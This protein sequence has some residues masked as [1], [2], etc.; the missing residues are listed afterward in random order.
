[1]RNKKMG[2]LAVLVMLV[3]VTLNA[4]GGTYAK[5]ISSYGMTDEARV[6]RWDFTDEKEAT[7]T[8]DLFQQSYTVA[9]NDEGTAVDEHTWVASSD[10]WKV[11]APGT[12]GMYEYSIKGTAET[13]FK[14][15]KVLSIT[16][17][18]VLDNGYDPLE[19]STDGTNWVKSSA[20]TAINDET[21]YPANAN[22]TVDGKLYWRWVYE[23]GNDDFD[24]ELGKKAVTDDLTIVATVGATVEQTKDVPTASTLTMAPN[25]YV[26]VTNKLSDEDK[27]TLA[28]IGY[29]AQNAVTSFNGKVLSG[30]VKE[31][32]ADDKLVK[33]FNVDPLDTKY[34]VALKVTVPAG[35]K[36]YNGTA[37]EGRKL[38][39][40][41]TGSSD[42][43]DV[44]MPINVRNLT[45]SFKYS[46]VDTNN[47]EKEY[48]I[49]YQLTA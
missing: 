17:N 7:R 32:D 4:V 19:F 10:A 45:G 38:V 6:A 35:T 34:F 3:A 1:M 47:N 25:A 36:L 21:V 24:T 14:V 42:A 46:L 48:T 27:A 18:V 8:V 2:I 9:E 15:K 12:N 22:I 44:L 28:G 5:Y 16:N 37:Y 30:T 20:I 33:W 26:S 11:I 43:V 29:K 39:K 41:N 23:T 40:D 31:Y 49:D 13:N